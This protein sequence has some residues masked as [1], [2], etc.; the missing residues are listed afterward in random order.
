MPAPP[1]AELTA[2]LHA[3]PTAPALLE[4]LPA[5][6]AVHLVGGAVR[7]L[8]LGGAPP[9]LDL[10]VEGDA[11]A[12]ARELA[13]RMGGT[14]TAYEQFG[15]ATVSAGDRAYD[16]ACARRERYSKPGAL[17]EVEAAGLDED[18]QR[19]DFTVNAMAVSLTPGRE[20]ELQCVEGALEDLADRRLR[21]LHDRSFVDDPTRLLRLARYAARLGFEPGSQTSKLAVNAVMG[22]A[23]ATVSGARIGRE[24]LLLLGEPGALDG[25]DWCHR[26]GLLRALSPD[27]DCD[28]ELAGG[29]LALLPAD[30]RAD[31][32]LLAA[33]SRRMGDRELRE[34]LDHLE[35][36]ARERERVAT[37]AQDAPGY[38]ER[39]QGIPD[40]RPSQ[41]AELLRGRPVEVVALAGALGPAE[42]VRRWLEETRY[43]EL[44]I[45]GQDLV[46]AGVPEGPELGR[47]LDQALRRKLDGE[48]AGREAE[49][50]AALAAAG[51]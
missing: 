30:G 10:V 1:S 45:D 35:L 9:D 22:G 29:A 6:P 13:E 25:L 3:L 49:L 12:L 46:A 15:T 33:C 21:I 17:P 14:V 44:E 48:L 42:P 37:A 20:G 26:L 23:L 8:L 2:R 28:R 40:V 41:L 18:L 4:A 34:W 36:S 24:L 32:L 51:R 16:L 31:L 43:V 50:E 39:L 5:E 19:R 7:D 38:A 11:I 47:A 27:L